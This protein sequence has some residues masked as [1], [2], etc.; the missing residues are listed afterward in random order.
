MSEV[1]DCFPSPASIDQCNDNEKDCK[2]FAEKAALLF[3]VGRTFASS[4]QLDQAAELFCNVWAVKKTH[5]GKYIGCNYGKSIHS[6][7]SRLHDNVS[8]RQKI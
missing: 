3:P 4:K 7:H 2:L 5:P 8:K 1:A 6:H